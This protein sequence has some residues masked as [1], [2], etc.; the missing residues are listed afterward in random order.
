MYSFTNFQP[1]H[2]CRSGSNCCFFTSIQVSQEASKVA[3]Y[4]Q[5]FKKFSQVLN[6]R[7]LLTIMYQLWL[8]NYN[9]YSTKSKISIT[10]ET[11][12]ANEVYGNFLYFLLNLFYKP[13]TA[14]NKPINFL[15]RWCWPLW[16]KLIGVELEYKQESNQES[17]AMIKSGDDGR[18]D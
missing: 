9:K 8:I 18:L 7:F 6:Y 12:G 15:K 16:I 5:L 3:W 11:V 13:E 1:V 4:S 2:W 17:S 14:K 10:G